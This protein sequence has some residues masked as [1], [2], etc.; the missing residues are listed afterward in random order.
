MTKSLTCSL[1]RSRSSLWYF[2]W[3]QPFGI[4]AVDIPCLWHFSD[5]LNYKSNESE[6]VCST[7]KSIWVYILSYIMIMIEHAYDNHKYNVNV[8]VH[9]YDI[10]I[11]IRNRILW[12]HMI[13]IYE[14]KYK[15]TYTSTYI[16]LHIWLH[17]Y[18]CTY[19]IVRIW[20]HIW[21][22]TYDCTYMIAHIWVYN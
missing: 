4:A 7:P 22:H 5:G 19:M 6:S 8:W 13:H 9:K 17:I 16:W 18:D 10:R 3:G 12:T 1:L 2:R 20:L 21:L 14:L 15:Y 11:R